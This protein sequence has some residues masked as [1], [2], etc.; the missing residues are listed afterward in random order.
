[1]ELKSLSYRPCVGAALFNHNGHVWVGKRALQLAIVGDEFWQMPQGGIEEGETPEF[2]ILREIKEETGIENV[3]IISEIEEWLYYDLPNNL[4]NKIWNG[5]YRGQKQ[6]WF[7]VKF[8][9]EDRDV[10]LTRQKKP[11]FSQWKWV[12]IY[13]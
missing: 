1:M 13:C 8:R 4:V 9:G 7:A 3:E 12:R 2:A 6:K 11:E 5:K 10:C